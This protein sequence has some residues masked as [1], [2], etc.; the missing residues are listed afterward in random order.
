MNRRKK[1]GFTLV[2]MLCAIIVLLLISML[3][4]VGIKTAVTAYEKEVTHSE[5]QILCASI[6]TVVSDELRYSGTTEKSGKTITFFSQTYGKAVSF[7]SNEDGQVLLGGN[8]ILAKKAY[9]YGMM[10]RVELLSYDETTRVFSAKVT[11]TD[12]NGKTLAESAFE[13]EQLNKN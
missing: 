10:A 3:M 7:T 11:V 5:S 13:V 2:E 4:A 6:R 8:K 1:S 9:P 12:K